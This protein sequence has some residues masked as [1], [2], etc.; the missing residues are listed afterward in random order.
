MKGIIDRFEGDF[1]VVEIEG[2]TKDFPKSIFPIE[3]K[4][5]DIIVISDNLVK[6]KNEETA[7]LRKEIEQL[8]EEVWED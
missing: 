8:M 4:P 1:V 7:E 2:D 3:A 5:G 6:I